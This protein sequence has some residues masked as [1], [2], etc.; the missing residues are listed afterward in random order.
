[1]LICGAARAEINPELP[2]ELTGYGPGRL[3]TRVHDDLHVAALYLE[4]R[5]GDAAGERLAVLTYDMAHTGKRFIAEVQKRCAAATG[6]PERSILTT[7]SHAH[8][9]P[10]VRP[11]RVPEGADAKRR[12]DAWRARVVERS[13]EALKAALDSAQPATVS[14]N[15]TRIRENVNRRVFLPDGTYFYQPKHKYLSPVADGPVD[16]ELGMLYFRAAHDGKTIATVVNY[17]A[18]PLTVGDSSDEVTADYPGVLK[19]E[20][21]RNWGGTALFITG[22]AGDNH[23]QGAEAGFARCE[24]MGLALAEKVLYHRWDAVRLDDP[25]VASVW[26]DIVL[27]AMTDEDFAR[28]PKDYGSEKR[29]T[30]PDDAKAEGGLAVSL[31]LWSIGPVLFIGTPGELVAELGL[32]LKWESPFPK[33]YVMYLATE[34]LGYMAHRNAF[35]WGGYEAVCTRFGPEAGA[36]FCD[37][38]LSAAKE[39][40]T[41][42]EATGRRVALPGGIRGKE[43]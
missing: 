11:D 13:V 35:A 28:V 37:A 10:T 4:D 25:P 22:A 43:D 1:M 9:S 40:K 24:R 8:S 7:S 14:C 38:A 42:V 32:R 18:H 33:T 15:A 23:P 36:R 30:V 34:H 3:A 21:E 41:R 2:I 12:H 20:I 26:R 27:P 16:D 29:L 6:L 17:T 31:C 39:L 19:R 5:A